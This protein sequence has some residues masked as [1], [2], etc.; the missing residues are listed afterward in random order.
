MKDITLKNI[1]LAECVISIVAILIAAFVPLATARLPDHWAGD[2]LPTRYI[3]IVSYDGTKRAHFY[4]GDRLIVNMSH[5]RRIVTTT[6]NCQDI[7]I[8]PFGVTIPNRIFLSVALAYALIALI[9][10]A[11]NIKVLYFVSNLLLVC[12][13]YYC[14][15]IIKLLFD[16]GSINLGV[17]SMFLIGACAA[18]IICSIIECLQL[19]GIFTHNIV[20]KQKTP[21]PIG[22]IENSERKYVGEVKGNRCRI[23]DKKI[24]ESEMAYVVDGELLCVECERKLSES[25]GK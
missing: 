15:Y 19:K 8:T 18:L 21:C 5:Y 17:G 13:M 12:S 6:I 16:T 2:N 24:D 22:D 14:G 1:P 11:S 9:K 25:E 3:N 20:G 7:H 10:A 23:C 4:V